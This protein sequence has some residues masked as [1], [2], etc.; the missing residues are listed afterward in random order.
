MTPAPFFILGTLMFESPAFGWLGSLA[1]AAGITGVVLAYTL[2]LRTADTGVGRYISGP[3]TRTGLVSLRLA[4]IVCLFLALWHPACVRQEVLAHRPQ[5]AIVLD[6]SASMSQPA[7]AAGAT[8]KTPSRYDAAVAALD[9]HLRPALA[10]THDLRVFDVQ[11]RVL[12]LAQLPAAAVNPRSPLTETLLD[13]QHELADEPPVGIVLLS[14]GREVSESP[15]TGSIEQLRI[16]VYVVQVAPDAPAGARNLAVQAV[17]VNRRA[18]VNNTVRAT[19]DIAGDEI[20]PDTRV[21]ATILEGPQTVASATLKWPAGAR[22]AR[23]E[24]TFV[25]RRPGEFTYAVQVGPLG[26]DAAGTSGEV[27]LADNRQTFPLTVTAQPLTILYIDGVLRWEGKFIHEALSGDPDIN[28]IMMVRTAPP[29]TDRGSQGLLL[30]EQLAKLNLVIL[31]DVEA[32]FFST[33]ELTAL[34]KWVTDVGGALLLTGGYHSFGPGGFGGSVLRDIL[35]VEFSAEPNPQSDQPFSLQLTDAGREHPIFQLTGDR[36]RDTA[37]FQTLPPLAGFSRIAGVK[38]GGQ[39]LAVNP[40]RATADASGGLP[41]LVVQEVGAGRTMVFAVDTTWRWR[42]V[43]GGFTGDSSFYPRFWGQLVRYLATKKD[44]PPPRLFVST[45]RYRYKVGQ[46][47]EVNIETRSLADD[48]NASPATAPSAGRYKVAATALSERGEQWSIPVSELPDG[49]FHGSLAAAA[50]GRLDL[51]VRAEPL[52]SAERP[53]SA[54]KDTEDLSAIATVQVERPDLET[55]DPRPDPQW[56][57]QVAQ[58]TGG[59]VLRPDEI[60]TWAA[61]LPAQPRQVTRAA[62]SGLLGERTLGAV[63]LAL[64]CT[65]WI[66]RRWSR[67]P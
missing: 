29:G 7:G 36:T 46:T 39:V 14:D 24:L 40:Q 20:A 19:V 57:A 67:L 50:A 34:S 5:L 45:D 37:F 33:S 64:V 63:F 15:A 44:E 10:R 4:A 18:L 35:P 17:S 43:V 61:T 31:G 11:G 60:E 2:G 48:P 66:L 1:L 41:V 59:R 51:H 55:L 12:N 16:P 65:E 23:T 47:V 53:P 32:G 6:D 8:G 49:R 52:H 27:D 9:R 21:P 28:M 56:L 26:G 58:L 38:P 30:P 42:M 54:D 62:S 22:T 3:R 13:V 25:P